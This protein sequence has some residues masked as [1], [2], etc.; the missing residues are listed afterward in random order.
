[1]F[2]NPNNFFQ[3]EFQLFWPTVKKNCSTDW[4]KLLDL[5]SVEQFIQAMKGHNNY[6]SIWKKLLGFRNMQEKLEKKELSGKTLWLDWTWLCYHFINY[7]LPDKKF[8]TA[9]GNGEKT[10]S[11]LCAFADL[12]L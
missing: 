10:L 12:K 3:F 5:K 8:T 7:E 9:A 2:L 11:L 1:M 4:E 6:N